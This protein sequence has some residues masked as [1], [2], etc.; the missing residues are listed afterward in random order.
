MRSTLLLASL[1]LA[2]CSDQSPPSVNGTWVATKLAA[3]YT[4][5]L[6]EQDAVVMGSGQYDNSAA[7]FHTTYTVAGSY[8]S[9]GVALVF[10]YAT[11]GSSQ[12]S[13]DYTSGNAMSGIVAVSPGGGADTLVFVKQ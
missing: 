1:A 3:T 5:I 2:A 13:A 12:F 6:S 10:T 9:P 4:M 7:R 8:H 11:S